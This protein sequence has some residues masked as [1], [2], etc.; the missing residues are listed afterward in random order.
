Q[1]KNE[2]SGKDNLR[3]LVTGGGAH[4]RFLT[5]RLSEEISSVG[6]ELIIPVNELIDFK[7]ALVMALMGALRWR[8]DINVMHSVT[9]AAKDSINGSVWSV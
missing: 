2:I 4:N 5:E 9:G 3:L 8:E 1:L 6:I 7:E